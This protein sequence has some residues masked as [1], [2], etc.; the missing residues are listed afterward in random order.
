MK[1]NELKIIPMKFLYFDLTN[2][3][4][5]KIEKNDNDGK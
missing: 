3:F 5:L 1:E 4:F 2:N